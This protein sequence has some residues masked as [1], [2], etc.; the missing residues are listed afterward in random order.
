MA[1]ASATGGCDTR[2]PF[3][4][5]AHIGTIAAHR[6]VSRFSLSREE[7][8]RRHDGVPSQIVRGTEI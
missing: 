4:P 7:N 6:S 3:P 5:A 8:T 1:A 2:S